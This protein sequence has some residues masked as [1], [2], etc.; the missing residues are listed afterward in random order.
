VRVLIAAAGSWRHAPERASFEEYLRRTPWKITLQEC[1]PKPTGNT[2]KDK[3][4]EAEKLLASAERFG[5]ERRI[6]LDEHG[7]MLTS[8]AFAAQLGAWRDQGAGSVVFFIGGHHGLAE[9]VRKRCD[10]TLAFGAMTWP[11]LLARLMLAEQ[12]YRAS[13]ILSGHP[14]HRE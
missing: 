9:E 7:K 14:Y 10:L 5:A 1:T 4:A 3:L 12:L 8:K 2:E 11:H 13:A 6:A